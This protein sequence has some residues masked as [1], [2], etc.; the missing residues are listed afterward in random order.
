M[1][2]AVSTKTLGVTEA[3]AV[4]VAGVCPPWQRHL[5]TS[6]CRA[7]TVGIGTAMNSC[8]SVQECHAQLIPS[9]IRAKG[10]NKTIGTEGQGIA[11]LG[12]IHECTRS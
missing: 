10:P 2:V 4:D 1:F 7:A 3:V 12:K 8:A 6:Y 11:P 5:C 9:A